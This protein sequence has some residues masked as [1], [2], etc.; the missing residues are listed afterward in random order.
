LKIREVILS[1]TFLESSGSSRNNIIWMKGNLIH[2]KTPVRFPQLGDGNNENNCR[3]IWAERLDRYS[4]KIE[5]CDS[6]LN[7][8]DSGTWP[9]EILFFESFFDRFVKLILGLS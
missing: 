5:G 7:V 1:K 3:R 4:L 8:L 2:D 9:K 6:S